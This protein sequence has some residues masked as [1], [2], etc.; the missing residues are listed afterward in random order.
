MTG[1]QPYGFHEEYNL[2]MLLG[3][4]D[5]DLKQVVCTAQGELLHIYEMIQNSPLFKNQR[6]CPQLDVCL[7]LAPTLER[8][9]CNGNGASLGFLAR[10]HGISRCSVVS[11]S[12]RFIEA[13]LALGPQ[14][15]KWP[16]EGRRSQISASMAGEGFPGCV[17]FLD[18]T[19]IPLF[20][21]PGLEREV[22]Y[23]CNKKYSLNLRRVCDNSKRITPLLS[24]WP[25][26][27]A[28]S[29]LYKI[30]GLY[31]QPDKF[32]SPGE[33]LAIK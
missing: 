8:L 1:P 28:D 26:S 18:G 21:R 10:S 31:L 16:N 29:T 12:Q 2:G 7:Q 3:M 14:L 17:G 11:S 30:M 23:D 20:Q 27:C 22:Y 24:G 33:F 4:R 6:N 25:G 15:V 9:G 5:N 19:T 32:F 13:L